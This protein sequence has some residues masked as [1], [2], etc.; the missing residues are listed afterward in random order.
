MTSTFC[1][2]QNIYP[3]KIVF[4]GDTCVALSLDLV[5]TLNLKLERK[6]YLEKQYQTLLKQDEANQAFLSQFKEQIDQR[7]ILIN[8]LK[9]KA[10]E[11]ETIA[12]EEA[13][14]NERLV[15][16]MRRNNTFMY[17]SFAVAAVSTIILIFK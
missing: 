8:N 16:K 9:Q 17:S 4:E 3:R 12:I 6:G 5:K 15:K 13:K 2:S 10:I 1:Y 14:L 7:D 11:I